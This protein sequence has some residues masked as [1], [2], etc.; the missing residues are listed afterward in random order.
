MRV[1]KK[2]S[3]VA[4]AMVLLALA[5]T[6]IAQEKQP[7]F[8]TKIKNFGFINQNYFRGA[9][10]KDSDYQDLA[11]MGVKT[12][13]D[14]Q[15]RSSKEGQLVEA[16]GMKYVQVGMKDDERPTDEQVQKVLQIVN[17]PANQPV[18]VHC[19][20]GRHRTGLITAVYRM[21]KDGWDA[22]KAYDEMKQFDFGYG[23]G[24]GALKDYVLDY[25]A[26]SAVGATTVNGSSK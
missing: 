18:F 1:V 11:A 9:Q 6:S 17:D 10:P 15:M 4:T 14:L 16:A 3:F 24:H 25:H 8:K 2:F 23:F 22:A 20:G 5:L 21:E 7:Y 13:I 26:H 12:V 19:K